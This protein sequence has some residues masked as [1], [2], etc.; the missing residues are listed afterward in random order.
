MGVAAFDK[1]GAFGVLGKAR[2]QADTTKFIE[3]PGAHAHT[4]KLVLQAA[5]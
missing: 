4:L 1:A 2:N 5:T 3:S